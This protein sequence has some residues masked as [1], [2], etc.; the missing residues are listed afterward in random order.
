MYLLTVRLRAL[1][2]PES[3]QTYSRHLLDHFSH[4]AED[5]MTVLHGMDVRGM[6]N[7]YLKDLFLQWR[8][9]LAAY[10]E[11]LVRGDAVLG[12]AVWRNLWKGSE[13]GPDGKEVDWSKVARVVAYMRRVLA[14]LGKEH[15]SN[16][17]FA[18]T[19]L[20]QTPGK[21]EGIFGFNDRDRLLVEGRSLGLDEPFGEAKQE[22]SQ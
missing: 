7:R 17:V 1:Q 12:A 13:V 10:D 6:R 18:V 4:R 16:L 11:G 22:S 21:K 9:V 19:G 2:S 15:E 14:D 8:G 3:V 20:Y 5:R